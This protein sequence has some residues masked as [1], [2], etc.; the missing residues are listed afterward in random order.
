MKRVDRLLSDF[1]FLILVILT[2]VLLVEG[3]LR[4]VQLNE[5]P[6]I[7]SIVDRFGATRLQPLLNLPVRLPEYQAIRLVTD[8]AGARVASVAARDGDRS[9][10]VLFVGDSQVLG[11]GLSFEH[12]AASRLAG[13][14]GIP[15]DKIAILAAPA[16][17]P[18]KEIGWARDYSR[19]WRQRQRVEVVALNLGNDLEEIYL[20]RVGTLFPSSGG[21]PAWLSRHSLAYID[22]TLLRAS[23]QGEQGEPHP[24]VNSAMLWLNEDERKLLAEG[25]ADSVERLFTVLP[26]ADRRIVMV[27]PQDSQV[28]IDEFD[29]YRRYYS[30]DA[31][32]KLH[33]A[34]QEVA[35][36][37]LEIVQQVIVA[38]LESRGIKVVLVEPALSQA[39][40]RGQL[41]DT[42]SHHLMNAGQEVA[43]RALVPAATGEQ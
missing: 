31:D 15:Q 35:L 7:P 13:I 9:N 21:L 23:L 39:W 22:L 41:I 19:R 16:E 5:R 8:E 38:K 40:G 42:R 24:E 17:D 33:K 29:K 27:I 32:F 14:I 4:I 11:W 30:D 37:R 1:V 12:T 36:D 28:R 3:V 25:A 34:A 20:T 26:P 18:E 6:M 43:A 2:C 10:G